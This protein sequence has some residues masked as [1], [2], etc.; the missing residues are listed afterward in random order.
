MD[1]FRLDEGSYFVHWATVLYQL[2]LN[3][4]D[5]ALHVVRQ[6]A[7]EPI[8]AAHAALSRRCAAAQRSTRPS[9]SSCSTGSEVRIRKRLRDRAHAGLLRPSAATRCVSWSAA[10]TATTVRIPALDLDPIWAGLRGDPEFQRIR[11]KAMACHDRFRRMVEAY[12]GV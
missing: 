3:D 2:R 11:A 5:A 8:A 12:G 9:P 1:F 6:A 4:R 10:W 7:D